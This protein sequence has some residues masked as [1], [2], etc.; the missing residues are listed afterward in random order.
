MLEI[1]VI[2]NTA[3]TPKCLHHDILET[4]TRLDTTL[5]I[6]Y[7]TTRTRQTKSQLDN[8]QYTEL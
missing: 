2:K 1:Q 3:L 8:M 7:R 6:Y 5:K 4:H